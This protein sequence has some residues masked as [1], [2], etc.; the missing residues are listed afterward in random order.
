VRAPNL[1]CIVVAEAVR[2]GQAIASIEVAE[3]RSQTGDIFRPV[4]F[5]KTQLT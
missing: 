3:I 1:S 2:Y 4:L 5:L